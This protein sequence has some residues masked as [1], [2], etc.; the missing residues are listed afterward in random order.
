M[1][2]GF[3]VVFPYYTLPYLLFMCFYYCMGL[4]IHSE[5]VLFTSYLNITHYSL[6]YSV[7]E[8]IDHV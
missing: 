7:M 4:E 5:S 3:K 6:V 1:T 2:K 8:D